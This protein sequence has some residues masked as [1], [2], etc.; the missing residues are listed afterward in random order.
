VL[1]HEW[2]EQVTVL[3]A[4]VLVLQ[5]PLCTTEPARGRADLA[6][7][8]EI[9]ADPDCAVRG[10]LSLS[11]LKVALVGT[12]EP[13]D[14]VV[15]ATE[16]EG[17][18]RE[19]L[20]VFRSEAFPLVH[21][22]QRIMRLEPGPLRVGVAASLELLDPIPHAA[23]HCPMNDIAGQRTVAPSAQNGRA[24]PGGALL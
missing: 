19:Q 6:T 5:D 15:V 20:E 17:A 8:C 4:I 13:G 18:D 10:S 22:R 12:F 21:D 7:A 2:E 11:G 14:R 16:H 23:A 9:Q 3:G 24:P 1:E